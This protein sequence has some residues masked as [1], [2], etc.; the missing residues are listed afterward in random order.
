MA[1]N[2][3]T[4]IN[5]PQLSFEIRAS[6]DIVKDEV[7][8]SFRFNFDET[9]KNHQTIIGFLRANK[10]YEPDVSGFL[11][12]VLKEGDHVVDV[13]ANIGFHSM[14]MASLVGQSGTVEAFEPSQENVLEINANLKS[15]KFKNVNIHQKV[16]GEYPDQNLQYVFNSCDSGTSFVANGQAPAGADTRYMRS[17]TLDNELSHDKKIKVI[18]MDVEGSEVAILKGAKKILQEH[19]VKYWIIEYCPPELHRMGETL[20]SLRD[21]M[22]NFGLEMFVLD[23]SGGFPKHIP[24]NVFTYGK[25]LQNLLFADFEQLGS[26]WIAD[27][28][29]FLVSGQE[30]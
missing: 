2:H 21:Y 1:E 7:I 22:A 23:Y 9:K 11:K 20:N 14:L 19:L 18:K 26:D 3:S 15:N 5:F 4:E 30:S 13:G 16:L 6:G 28:I 24:R 17:Y 8:K 10:L 25:Y 29:T 27:D 12:R